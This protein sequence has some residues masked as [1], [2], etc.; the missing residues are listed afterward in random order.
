VEIKALDIGKLYVADVRQR[1][2]LGD[3]E[4]LQ[5]SIDTYGL[6]VP[7]IVELE[8]SGMYQII[9]G[10]RRFEACKLL[11]KTTIDCILKEEADPLI[12]KEIEFEE[13]IRR[14]Q[15]NW[16]EEA[17][18]R[19]ELHRLKKERY[20]NILSSSGQ[21]TW[22][23]KST[24]SDL[25]VSEATISQDLQ[26]VEALATNPE[27]GKSMTRN[28]AL[29]KL[30][31]AAMGINQENSKL[32]LQLKE[33]FLLGSTSEIDNNIQDGFCNLIIADISTQP[34]TGPTLKLVHDKLCRLGNAFI[35]FDLEQ[36]H[37]I[38]TYLKTCDMQFR[39]KPFIW[40][41]KGE[42][43]YQPFIWMSKFLKEAPI[44]NDHTS[45]R[46]EKDAL[47]H[48]AKPYQLYY[49]L[50]DSCTLQKGYVLG[51]NIFDIQLPKCI[52]ET[53]RNGQAYCPNVI[54]HEQSMLNV[55]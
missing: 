43:T 19:A 28:E 8:P 50:I 33:N 25:G 51:I 24:A 37:D 45:F 48:K 42:D 53:F 35:F 5:I 17:T 27:L 31:Y 55:K 21:A 1:K 29:R 26:L 6:L 54:V 2:D 4:S 49:Q 44:I 18:T 47:H 7:I 32:K 13:N 52:L 36:Y 30:R 15:L 40:H 11:G 12:K 38:V 16:L 9:A 14:K 3:L 23:Q 22:N 34:S 41:K 10:Q 39:P 46:N 20:S